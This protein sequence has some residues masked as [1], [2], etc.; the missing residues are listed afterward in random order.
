V[1]SGSYAAT[2]NMARPPYQ[3]MILRQNPRYVKEIVCVRIHGVGCGIQR[4]HDQNDTTHVLSTSTSESF[5]TTTY[6]TVSA[7]SGLYSWIVRLRRHPIHMKESVYILQVWGT[8]CG[9]QVPLHKN[10]LFQNWIDKCVFLQLVFT[11]IKALKILLAESIVTYA[12]V[13]SI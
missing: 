3:A 11:I 1:R 10:R 9:S 2:P 7:L 8:A 4:A 12:L 6:D 13:K 5:A